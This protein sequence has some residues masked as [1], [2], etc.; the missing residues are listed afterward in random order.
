[1]QTPSV[2]AFN[3]ITTVRKLGIA[4]ETQLSSTNN[5]LAR[6]ALSREWS[7]LSNV[8]KRS[9]GGCSKSRAR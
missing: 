1:M 4:P 6:P 8:L 7:K 5:S 2:N 9:A 3:L